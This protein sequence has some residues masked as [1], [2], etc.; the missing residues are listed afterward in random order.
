[1]SSREPHA[2]HEAARNALPA[3]LARIGASQD[4][5]E[6]VRPL[7]LPLG[8]EIVEQGETSLVV[9][10]APGAGDAH[11]RAIACVEQLLGL[12]E[13][14][15][16]TIA[17]H[18]I[19]P[20][21]T[22]PLEARKLLRQ[23]EACARPGEILTS[24]PFHLLTASERQF[25]VRPPLVDRG[26]T[27]RIYRLMPGFEALAQ[28]P[29]IGRVKEREQLAAC[30]EVAQ[31]GRT[32][33][34]GIHGEPGIGKS[35]L[36]SFFASTLGDESRVAYA[37]CHPL[38]QARPYGLLA[39]L[40]EGWLR[41]QRAAIFAA[42]GEAA[43]ELAYLLGQEAAPS[44]L[45][46]QHRQFRAFH[47][48]NQYL[49]QDVLRRPLVV[50]LEDM[51]W[52]DEAS[53]AWLDALLSEIAF[54]DAGVPLMLIFTEHGDEVHRRYAG[55]GL[56]TLRLVLA[57][58]GAEEARQLLEQLLPAA[59]AALS[60][61]LALKAGGNP[62]YLQEFAHLATVEPVS[63]AMPKAI[64]WHLGRRFATLSEHERSVL[65]VA[66]V[67][68]PSWPM[69]MLQRLVEGPALKH[70]MVGLIAGEILRVPVGEPASSGFVHH[71][72]QQ[73]AYE[74]MP[75]SRRQA[76]HEAI[77]HHMARH[78]HAPETV[79]YHRLRCG[80][81]VSAV[82]ALVE[83]AE[84]AR[85][86]FALV[87]AR[88][89][90]GLA[91]QFEDSLDESR[92]RE[93]RFL[94]AEIALALGDYEAVRGHVQMLQS[95]CRGEFRVRLALLAS[96]AFIRRGEFGLAAAYLHEA[97][98]AADHEELRARLA[99]AGAHLALRQG[100]FEACRAAAEQA[101]QWLPADSQ[102]D[103][104][105]A[106]SLQGIA[107]YRLEGPAASLAAHQQALALREA[108]GELA[109]VGGSLVN[110]G[111]A[112]YE[113]G[114]WDEALALSERASQL[115]EQLGERWQA[116]AACNNVGNVLLNR[117]QYEA[118]ASRYARAA[119]IKRQIRDLPGLA[120]ALGNQGNALS[121]LGS[122]G[123]ARACLHESLVIL[124]RLGE[125]EVLAEAYQIF[126]MAELAAGHA[127]R[128]R[129]LLHRALE[130]TRQSHR[131]GPGA[132]AQRGLAQLAL[133]ADKLDDAHSLIGMAL[134]T[135]GRI[136][137]P[138]EQGRCEVVLA[139]ILRRRGR[140]AETR[141]ILERAHARFAAL[142]AVPDLTMIERLRAG[143]RP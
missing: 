15:S 135:L 131:E 105:M 59:P 81:P 116:S 16:W 136:R 106:L 89:H 9:A 77:A 137:N 78:F 142:G 117:G 56:G 22:Y 80:R 1:M 121:R 100:A 39:S 4:P 19:E 30:W 21:P 40:W 29:F 47:A 33:L 26:Q 7:L 110:L 92:C 43:A 118:A 141:A 128:A 94:D 126:G 123:Q 87:D 25:E 130:I 66:A 17:L 119:A 86:R 102:R 133:E 90:L 67:L 111:I 3:V 91:L 138:L 41:P 97:E 108:S 53:L 101:M 63:D 28:P 36:A 34:V 114:H 125:K 38:G 44:P 45:E 140:E 71:L 49:L 12:G 14:L 76:L 99:L 75:L 18:A 103:R 79:A 8:A 112:H 58:L 24:E 60:G 61:Q 98:P 134:E 127:P 48:F 31:Q 104:A 88:R 73:V 93:L 72:L 122:Y 82:P 54:R 51:Q 32:L 96:D 124:E 55:L 20:G 13:P 69:A 115:F 2:R 35:R 132:I 64:R 5:S 23:L 52:C 50:I 57:P 70:G 62:F 129:T 10:F 83:A 113:L 46:P 107:T 85:S 6:R 74:A 143:G 109:A 84:Q 95:Q 68:G 27:I 11:R 37:R 42:M 120:I 65:E 139:Q